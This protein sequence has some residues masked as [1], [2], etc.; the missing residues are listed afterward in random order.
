MET[1]TQGS[2][3][4]LILG[5]QQIGS[6]A[7][8]YE[9]IHFPQ[10]HNKSPPMCGFKIAPNYVLI[11]LK[12]EVWVEH[13]SK[14]L[15]RPKPR[16]GWVVVPSGSAGMNSLPDSFRLSVQIPFLVTVG[17][18][19]PFPCQLSDRCCPKIRKDSVWPMW[20][21]TIQSQ[22][23]QVKS[24]PYFKSLNFLFTAS[25]FCLTFPVSFRESFLLLRAHVIQL[26]QPDN[27]G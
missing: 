8:Q 23:E 18:R 7:D 1:N 9:F 11:A 12:S 14:I 24:F 17:L 10:L 2:R 22:Q 4:S 26:G 6:R 20:I 5:T 3:Q 13:D 25:L 19:T 27:A 21:P 15:Q 16:C